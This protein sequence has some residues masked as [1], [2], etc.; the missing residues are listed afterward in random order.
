MGMDR[1][2]VIEAEEKLSQAMLSS[3]IEAL[4]I[5]LDDDL[6]FTNHLGMVMTKQDDIDAHQQ[7]IIR[8]FNIEASERQIKL[9]DTSAVVSVKLKIRGSFK[10]ITSDTDLRFTRIWQTRPNKSVKMIAGHS[11]LLSA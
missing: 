3:D 5:L 2:L 11:C 7:G 9:F 1:N 4:E 10:G 6:I 8:I